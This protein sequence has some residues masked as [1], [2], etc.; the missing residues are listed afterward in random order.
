[1]GRPRLYATNIPR[2]KAVDPDWENKKKTTFYGVFQIRGRRVQRKLAATDI[3]RAAGEVSDLMEDAGRST[4]PLRPKR[5]SEA[6]SEHLESHE[7]WLKGKANSQHSDRCALKEFGDIYLSELTHHMIVAWMSKRSQKVKPATVNREVARLRQV[8]SYAVSRG[9]LADNPGQ[10]IRL[11]R[12]PEGRIRYL[13]DHEVESLYAGLDEWLLDMVKF[14]RLTGLRQSEQLG[15]TWRHV[16]HGQIRLEGTETKTHRR[17]YIPIKPTVAEILDRRRGKHKQLVFPSPTGKVWGPSNFRT[18]H[19]RPAFD[20]AGLTDFTWHDLRH[21]FCSQLVMLGADLYVV[22]E[23]AGHK[24]ITI[25]EKYAHLAPRKLEATLE[26][27]EPRPDQVLDDSLA[28]TPKR[29]D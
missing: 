21:D 5:L 9:W 16:E 25:T 2:V 11:F 22:K 27:L 14:A 3:T 13:L 18:R 29:A 19:W 24:T 6:Q 1:M 4:D 15:L 8:L 20:R 23:L 10:H 17:R 26:L 7:K 12:E 28:T